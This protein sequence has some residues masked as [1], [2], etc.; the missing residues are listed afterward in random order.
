MSSYKKS[1]IMKTAP[2]SSMLTTIKMDQIVYYT[3]IPKFSNDQ[4]YK[5]NRKVLIHN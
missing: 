2:V 5:Y 1:G 3:S 4:F